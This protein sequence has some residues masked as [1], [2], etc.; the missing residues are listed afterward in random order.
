MP[1]RVVLP[2]ELRRDLLLDVVF[3]WCLRCAIDGILLNVLVQSC[4]STGQRVVRVGSTVG[5]SNLTCAAQYVRN[6]RFLSQTHAG[7]AAGG[8]SMVGS[9]G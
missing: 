6:V 2:L 1:G 4:G 8:W 5:F 3:L 7:S 9:C